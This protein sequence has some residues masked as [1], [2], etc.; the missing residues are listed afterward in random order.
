MND[1]VQMKYIIILFIK[2]K[3]NDKVKIL[4]LTKDIEP[5]T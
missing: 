2:Y 3:K 4:I 1:R 5:H